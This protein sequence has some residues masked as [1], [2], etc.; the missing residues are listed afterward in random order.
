MS[1]AQQIFGYTAEG[2]PVTRYTLSDGTGFSAAVVDWGA[3]IVSIRTPDAQGRV[4][5]VV[6][7]FDRWEDYRTNPPYLGA[8]IGRFA[9]RIRNGRFTLHG[10]DQA[11]E[12]NEGGHHLHGGRP[13]F[14]HR[15]W[16]SDA[17]DNSVRMRLF[18]PDGDQGYPGG[19]HVEVRFSLASGPGLRIDYAARAEGDT[20][21]NLTNHAYFNLS[22]DP[23]KRIDGHHLQVASPTRLVV[24]AEWLPTGETAPVEG[25]V[26]DFRSERPIGT[27]PFN[28][29][30]LF[31]RNGASATVASV[32]EP[33]S[34]RVLEVETDQPGLL[35]YT[36]WG[37]PPFMGRDGQVCGP[38][39]GL[40]L[41]T[42][43][44]PDAPN[45]P[46]FPSTQLP[47]GGTLASM[48]IYR[49]PPCGEGTR[50]EP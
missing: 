50:G 31:E 8:T 25:T 28:E 23:A 47:A 44:P 5:D 24:D 33:D 40:C 41:E 7:G 49:F 39:S 14:S 32:R 37:M 9:N 12:R 22:G 15:L 19:L 16:Q 11:L 27:C 13:G 34:G 4:A 10:R 42:Q 43:H 18:S 35:L 46:G 3:T 2:E 1:T 21:V 29:Y 38:C 26:Y 36:A 6:L 20:I 17:D 45:H 30:Y 48:T